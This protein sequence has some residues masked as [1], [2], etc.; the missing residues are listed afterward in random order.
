MAVKM[1]VTAFVDEGNRYM[2]PVVR[3]NLG[4]G[5]SLMKETVQFLQAGGKCFYFDDIKL[6]AEFEK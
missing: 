1:I 4:G 5:D 2:G 6:M 3:I